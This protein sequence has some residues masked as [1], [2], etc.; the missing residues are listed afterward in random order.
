MAQGEN[1]S[2]HQSTGERA[3]AGQEAAQDTSLAPRR[4]KPWFLLVAL[5]LIAAIVVLIARKPKDTQSSATAGPQV[6]TIKAATAHLGDIGYYVDALGTVT[7]VATVNLYSQVNGTVTDVHYS[8]GQ[9]VHR[10]D[11]LIDIDPRP[12]E[13]QL[14]E[15]EGTLQH[16]RSVLA[17]AEMDLARY[18]KAATQQAIAQQTYDDQKLAVEQYR[19]TVRNDIGQVQAAQ[20]QLSYCHLTSPINGRIGLRLI[21]RGNTVFS[22][23]SNP[24][25]IITQLQPVT[26]VFD[27]AEDNLGQVRDQILHRKA[28]P[29]DAFDRS[30]ETKLASGKLLT[31][32][33]QIDTSTGT[34]RFRAQFDN[35]D[36]TLYPNQFVNARLLV[37]TLKNAVLVPSAAV[38]RNGTQAFVYVVTGNTVKLQAVTELTTEGD[39]SAVTGI[40]AGTVVPVTGFDKLQSGSTVTIQ[41]MQAFDSGQQRL[42]RTQDKSGSTL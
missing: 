2:I 28:L 4:R 37:K 8:E 15:A 12:Y 9:M 26:V 42:E 17:Q 27:V 29:V 14:E 34:V 33:N 23:A 35:N 20:V 30:Q 24:L 3:P 1:E 25:V 10:G 11:P 38:Q 31:L 19:G 18:D 36:L 5:V 13:A 39:V 22:G 40:D 32:D 7:P 6:A 16:D 21:D 41:S